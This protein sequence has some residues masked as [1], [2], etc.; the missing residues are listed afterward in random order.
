MLNDRW[1]KNAVIYCCSVATFMDANGD[2]VGDFLG[3]TRRLDYLQ[4]LGVTAIWLMP[5]QP[6]PGKDDGYDITDY[7]GVDPRFGTLGD[8]VEFTH[9]AKLRGIRVIIDL[10]VNHTSD[11]HPWFQAARADVSSLYHDWY[12]WSDSK[13]PNAGEGMVFPGVQ[14]STWTR[15]AK[16]RK[17]YFHRF[18]DHQ[19]DL[20]TANPEVQAEILKIIGFW[21]Q[22]GVAGFRMDAVPFLIEKKG[23][24]LKK[25]IR[26]YGMLSVFREFSQWRMGE[27]VLLAEANVS[28]REN[29]QYFGRTGDRLQMMFNFHVNQHLFHSLAT[30]D[31]RSLVQ[32][33]SNT[34]DLP[35]T[36]QWALHLRNHDELDLSRLTRQQRE[37]V[38]LAFG[39]ESNMQLYHRGI[40]RRL[41]PM[42]N[43]DRRLVELANSL[44]FTLPGTPVLRYGDEIGMGDDLSL[45]ERS[46]SRTPMQWS[47]EPHGGFT[48]SEAPLLPVISGGEYGY[49]HVNVAAQRRDPESLLNWFESILKIRKEIPEIGQGE[50][51]VIDVGH[52]AV[53]AIRY[54]WL[55]T[56]V[57]FLHNFSD[58]S[59]E[60]FFHAS[61][62][63]TTGRHLI[64]LLG[65]EH[66]SVAD[67][68][69]HC[70]LLEAYGYRW[71]RLD[72]LG[73]LLN[74]SEAA[75]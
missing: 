17:Y 45:P 10:V 68:G 63:E 2:G 28:P 25:D 42:F 7:Y 50:F 43:G 74:P 55:E 73:Y 8:F 39:P 56:S 61:R 14:K 64:D 20:N 67:D 1:Y 9:G 69:R 57:L 24:G 70:V 47:A 5:F 60:V 41:A 21:L 6:S 31:T 26:Q 59:R 53:L 44:L 37:E 3:L 54:D 33:L 12:I 16:A 38:F 27:T 32:A 4:G 65:N 15:D 36:A 51:T 30:R 35:P 49:Q 23:A 18:Y 13:P 19:P 72:D 22:L 48:K 29:V 40:R 34:R 62:E 66:S 11:Q 75:P 46:C 52:H 71:F 58:I